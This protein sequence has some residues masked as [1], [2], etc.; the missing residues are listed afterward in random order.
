MSIFTSLE[1]HNW[2]QFADVKVLFHPRLTVLTGANGAGKTTLLHIL[3]RHWGWNIPYVSTPQI[4][5][6]GL[7]KYWGGFWSKDT[8]EPSQM[9]DQPTYDIGTIEYSDHS[10]AQLSVPGDANETFA[11]RIDPEPSLPG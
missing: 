2:R 7:W 3:N 11:V 6:K 10:P 4:T 9:L 1:I 5:R 8:Q